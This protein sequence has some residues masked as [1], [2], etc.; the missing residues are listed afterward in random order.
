MQRPILSLLI[1]GL[2][3]SAIATTLFQNNFAV[4]LTD[5]TRFSFDQAVPIISVQGRNEPPMVLGSA[6]NS[7]ARHLRCAI[8][9]ANSSLLPNTGVKSRSE[10]QYNKWQDGSAKGQTVKF[11]VRYRLPATVRDPWSTATVATN[12]GGFFMQIV[13]RVTSGACGSYSYIPIVVMKTRTKGSTQARMQYY[14]NDGSTGADAVIN[15]DERVHD[16]VADPLEFDVLG[17]FATRDIWHYLMIEI[18]FDTADEGGFFRLY[19]VNSD[20]SLTTLKHVTSKNTLS[21]AQS[22][23]Q[24]PA[25]ILF[26]TGIY[27]GKSP[28]APAE[29]WH[30]EAHAKYL[31]IYQ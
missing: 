14:K 2:A 22:G 12:D 24:T 25:G 18:K 5:Y 29:T 8:W 20:N 10:L 30:A 23:N 26:K 9:D 3:H 31:H 27:N 13:E 15:Y 1:A 7:D 6:T 11:A 17:E 16:G 4:N 28:S 21:S 19:R